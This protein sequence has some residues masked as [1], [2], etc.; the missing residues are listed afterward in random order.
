VHAAKPA[1]PAQPLRGVSDVARIAHG[2]FMHETNSF[3]LPLTDYATFCTHGSRPPVSR[4]QE[5]SDRLRNT[6]FAT[7][8]FLDV[9]EGQHEL[10]PLVWAAALAGGTVTGEA[11]ERI[12]AELI[13]ALSRAMPVDALY[14]DLHGAMVSEPFADGEGELIRRARAVVGERVPIAISLDY[15]ANVTPQMAGLCDALFGYLTYPHVD[16]TETGQRAARAIAT[17]LERGRA[18]ARAYRQVPF[19]IPLTSQC[20]TL[21]PSR[22]IVER[23]ERLVGG[24][25]LN[26]SYLAGFPPSDLADCGPTV[27]VHGYVQADVDAAADALTSEIIRREAEFA[28]DLLDPDEGVRRAMRIVAA[29]GGRVI[30]ADTQDNPGCGGTSD[31]TG[32]LAALVRNRAEAVVLGNLYDADAARKAHAAGVGGE[33]EIALGGRSGPAGVEPLQGR[34]RVEQLGDG[35][36]RTT[37]PHVGGRNIDL[38]PM[39]RLRIAGV[40]VVVTSRRM[41]AHDQAP[42]RHVGA[43]PDRYR[44]L[45][46]KSTVHFRADFGPLAD[47]ILIVIA[48][49]AHLSDTTRYPYTRMRAGVRLYPLGPAFAGPGAHARS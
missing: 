38:G 26:V 22:S 45:A 21:E 27:S 16:Q 13:A 4:G 40:D 24:S 28:V 36:M 23:A 6:S 1:A 11:Y 8:G 10:V 33:I 15:H 2:G 29:G 48:P 12:A 35:R 32:L 5:V 31:T 20:T 18:T 42:F 44:I 30:L 3:V 39:A 34:F 7:A 19:L 9:M 17:L 43:D 41:Q 47:Q 37:G 46:L 25:L 49:G 14:L